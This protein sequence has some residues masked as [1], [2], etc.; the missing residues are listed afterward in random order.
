MQIL[1]NRDKKTFNELMEIYYNTDGY[2]VENSKWEKQ[3]N[4]WVFDETRIV[5]HEGKVYKFHYS[6]ITNNSNKQDI[7]N[8]ECYYIEEEKGGNN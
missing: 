7:N 3:N 2:D 8:E 5:K 4:C 6:G 1:R